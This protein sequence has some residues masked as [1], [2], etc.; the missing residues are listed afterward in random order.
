M[1]CDRTASPASAKGTMI[2]KQQE[3]IVSQRV[4]T[5]M[6]RLAQQGAVQCR[7]YRIAIWSTFRKIVGGV[8]GKAGS[9][10]RRNGALKLGRRSIADG[11]G[12]A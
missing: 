10:V 9:Y 3:C 12:E 11:S 5:G 7:A 1:F 8:Y 6:S 2:W 4:L